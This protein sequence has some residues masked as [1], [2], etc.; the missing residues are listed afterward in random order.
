MAKEETQKIKKPTLYSNI[1]PAL[2][3]GLLSF[4]EFAGLNS[5]DFSV[6]E[7]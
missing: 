4:T 6:P 3:F 1:I 2:F 7:L 5:V